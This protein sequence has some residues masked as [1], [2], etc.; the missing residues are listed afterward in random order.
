MVIQKAFQIIR[1]NRQKAQSF[2]ELAIV[3]P[4]LLLILLGLVEV[5]FFIARYLDV[6]DLTREAARFASIRDPQLGEDA[7][8]WVSNTYDCQNATPFNFYYHTACIFSP[9]ANSPMCPAASR[10]CN[11]LNPLIYLDPKVDDVVIKIF[12]IEGSQNV[13]NVY[14]VTSSGESLTDGYWAFS[15]HDEVDTTHNGNWQRTCDPNDLTTIVDTES[16]Y[17]EALV[18]SELVTGSPLNKGFVSIEFYYCYHQV[19]NLPIANWFIPNPMRIHAY[20]LMPLPAAQPYP[21]PTTGP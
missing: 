11:G 10:F 1:T 4:I 3:L 8:D 21:T 18:E 6:M 19:L 13:T 16:H 9:P 7:A 17:T 12:T 2:V 20:T 15:D 5:S 14:P